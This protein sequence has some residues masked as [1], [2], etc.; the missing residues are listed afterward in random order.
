MNKTDEIFKLFSEKMFNNKLEKAD[1]LN[2]HG[3]LTI[4]F[5]CKYISECKVKSNKQPTWTAAIGSN[6]KGNDNFDIMAIGEA[7]SA[8]EG[9]GMHMGRR[10]VSWKDNSES[11]VVAFRDW[12][13][14]RYGT[15]P[16]FTDLA[17]C[18]VA[19]QQNKNV[20][21]KRF[22]NCIKYILLE[23]IKII[24]PKTILCIGNVSYHY[25]GKLVKELG[26]K[27][28]LVKLTHYSR[29]AQLPISIEDKMNII[30][31]WDISKS[32]PSKREEIK[33]KL[34]STLSH[35]KD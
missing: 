24:K 16:Y 13:A 17:K 35:F 25:M 33:K 22:K 2:H 23:E 6:K 34:L 5:T 27:T 11:P 9:I 1:F 4:S 26:M 31:D 14:C 8:S 32:D 21:K 30:W 28:N 7:P 18:G 10:F 19:N 20:L 12:A 15:V 3:R 29:Q